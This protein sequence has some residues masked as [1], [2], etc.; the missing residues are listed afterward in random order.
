M[1]TIKGK[2]LVIFILIFTVLAANSIIAIINF[3]TLKNSIDNILKANY[4]SVVYAQ[5]MAIA[6]E[7]QDSAELSMM[8]ED[9]KENPAKL[10]K[11]NEVNFLDWLE[12]AKSNITEKGEDLV[13]LNIDS[14]YKE[15]LNRFDKFENLLQ[16]NTDNEKPTRDYYYNDIFPL[17]ENIK[18]ECRNLLNINQ[19]KMVILKNE[20]AVIA[21]RATITNAAISVLTIAI[22]LIFIIYLSNKIIRSL[23]NLNSKIKEIAK[24]DYSQK[25]N[26]SGKDEIASLSKE[27]N[28]MASKLQAYDL[29]NINQL[30]KEKQKIE[31]IVES[32]S[33]GVIVTGAFNRI[34][35]INKA[36]E[37]I[38]N[39]S[40]EEYLKKDFTDAI[41]NPDLFNHIDAIRKDN[42]NLALKEYLD[43]TI[44]NKKD[45]NYY[46]V[47]S[48]PITNIA[49][50]SIGV[51]TLFQDITKFK[52]VEDLKSDFVAS[53][54][55]EL[56]TP[57]ASVLMAAELLDDEIP[58]KTNE[59]QKEI[60][61]IILEDGNRLKNLINDILDLSKFE[62]G[63]MHLNLKNYAPN[64]IIDYVLK[65]LEIRIMEEDVKINIEID[66]NITGVKADISKITQVFTNLIEN[67][68][69]Y[70]A[71]DKGIII[72]LGVKL[73]N[74]KALFFIKDNGR[75]I[76]EEDQ[77]KIFDKFIRLE[78]SENSKNK[79]SGLGLAISK[80]II[81]NHGGDLWVESSIGTGSTFY[82]TLKLAGTRF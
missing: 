19:E 15:Y 30:M 17:F 73:L 16:T 22:S 70:K 33:D 79:G 29:L 42:D 50:E 25:L 62:S 78:E 44:K 13:I 35:L 18:D 11:E 21:K 56:R 7:R 49:G 12:K 72:D 69:N 10:F 26:V 67:S 37:K 52:E 76:S 43:L 59:K 40:E 46:R 64:E 54:S 58:G 61:S 38:F 71:A 6:I 5:N 81:K 48:K 1:K 66:K 24:G 4:E 31:A 74:D 55:H 80:S 41:K 9:N 65:I 2:L 28:I 34:L 82:F 39:I 77:K 3:S 27:F 63:K 68:I 45:I 75:G 32:I 36:A 14:L 51:V 47:I 60:I 23:T 53:V 8:F 20:S 57:I